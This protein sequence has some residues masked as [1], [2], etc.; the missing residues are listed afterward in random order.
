MVHSEIRDVNSW[1]KN[2]SLSSLP[3][4]HMHLNVRMLLK[5]SIGLDLTMSISTI[6][7][8]MESMASKIMT[9]SKIFI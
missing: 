2:K 6:F 1:F 8:K 9:N 5:Q 7:W 4:V 3:R